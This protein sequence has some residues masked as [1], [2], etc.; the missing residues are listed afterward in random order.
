[1]KNI[2]YKN[3]FDLNK[4]IA[5]V[6]GSSRGIGLELAKGLSDYG[7]KVY[8]LGRT[9]KVNLSQS[10]MHYHKVDATKIT[11]VKKIYQSIFIKEKKIDILVNCLG[12]TE[13]VTPNNLKNIDINFKKIL[14]NNLFSIHNSCTIASSYM[15]KNGGSIINIS[16]IAGYQGFP[17]NPGYISSKAALIGLT[18][19]FAVDYGKY[20]IRANCIIPGYIKTD[21][22]IASYNNKN[23]NLS[24]KKRTALNRWGNKRELVGS[25][26][27]LSSQ[28]SSYITGSEIIVDGGWL[29]K[30]L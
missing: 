15:K 18:K 12:I 28:A 10:N 4:K 25:V 2:N 3:I 22:T 6:L 9:K 21:M 7:S 30:G 24:R 16:S 27:F 19:S 17:K 23:K 29:S 1:M 5:I 8:C 20:N 11:E 13:F 26:I 14:E